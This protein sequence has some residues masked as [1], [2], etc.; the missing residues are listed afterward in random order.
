MYLKQKRCG[1]IKGRGCADGRKQRLYKTKDETLSLTV[2]TE[3]FFF[4]SLIDAEEDQK[5]VTVD[6]PGAFMHS[7][8]DEELVHMRLSGPMA[9]LLVRVDP[10][11][12]PQ[13]VVKDKKGN[14][15][16]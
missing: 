3:A 15:T 5:V 2:S 6:T 11:K 16:L 12:Y 4:N 8:M 7:D 10:A 9:E 13:Y 14:D 1:R